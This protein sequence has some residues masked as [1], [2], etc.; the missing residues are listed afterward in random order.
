VAAF[1]DWSNARHYDLAARLA[2]TDGRAD[3][4]S[5]IVRMLRLWCDRH[6]HRRELAMLLDL[7]DTGVS[8]DLVAHEARKWPWQDWH[9]Q[10]R[11]F[12][13]AARRRTSDQT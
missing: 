12:E 3:I 4:Y 13:E 6:R 9:P 7:R 1:W 8:R 5:E 10:L 11:G 2:K